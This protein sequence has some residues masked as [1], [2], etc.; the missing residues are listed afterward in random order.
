M[1]QMT[2]ILFSSHSRKSNSQTQHDILLQF[3][4]FSVWLFASSLLANGKWSSGMDRHNVLSLCSSLET[5]WRG[6]QSQ[7]RRL[8]AKSLKKRIETPAEQRYLSSVPVRQIKD[9]IIGQTFTT[10]WRHLVDHFI[11]TTIF[12]IRCLHQSIFVS[13]NLD[14]LHDPSGIF[15]FWRLIFRIWTYSSLQDY[16]TASLRRR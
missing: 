12:F 1:C 5:A 2:V 3:L 10:L 14:L 7:L 16:T 6:D 15:Y 9:A 8:F 4:F 11:S 13:L